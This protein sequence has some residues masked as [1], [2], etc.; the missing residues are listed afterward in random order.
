MI[1]AHLDLNWGQGD[2][3]RGGRKRG[4]AART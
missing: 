1:S 3:G 2:P 4:E